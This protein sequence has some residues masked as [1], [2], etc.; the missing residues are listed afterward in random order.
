RRSVLLRAGRL[1]LRPT[2]VLRW[3]Q[4]WPTDVLR[5]LQ[6]RAD[7]LSRRPVCAADALAVLWPPRGG[8]HAELHSGHC[9]PADAGDW[10]DRPLAASDAAGCY[11]H[12][13]G[14]DHRQRVRA[15]EPDDPDRTDREVD[16]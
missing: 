15:S 2:D 6:L 7:V 1:Q 13:I 8:L 12:P 5:W 16:E 10:A 4:L 3:L 9:P 11:Q 14:L